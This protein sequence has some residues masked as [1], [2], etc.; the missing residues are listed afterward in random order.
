MSFKKEDIE[1]TAT[2]IFKIL[3]NT[4]KGVRSN[5]IDALEY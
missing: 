5:V 2:G 3:D 4:I 1:T